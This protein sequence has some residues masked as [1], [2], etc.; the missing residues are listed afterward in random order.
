MKILFV[1][2]YNAC[3]SQMAEGL[4]RN[5]LPPGTEVRSAGLYPGEVNRL[6]IEVMW[7]IGIDISRQRSK[8]LSEVSRVVFDYLVIL[9]EPAIEA[10]LG[11]SANER[12]HWLFD[13]PVRNPGDPEVL[14]QGVREVRDRLKEEIEGCNE[15][16]HHR[17]LQ[18]GGPRS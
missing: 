17:R 8:L 6:T 3:R 11:I 2:E 16:W 7:E 5:L 1:C 15:I 13:D 10:T 12:L 14:K 18:N 4:A 9:A